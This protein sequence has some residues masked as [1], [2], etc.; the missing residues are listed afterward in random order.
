MSVNLEINQ[1]TR[2]SALSFFYANRAGTVFHHPEVAE[3]L[4]DDIEWWQV[5]KG[6]EPFQLHPVSRGPDGKATVPNFS[7]HFGPYWSDA[8]SERPESSRFSDSQK[9]YK[10]VLDHLSQKYSSFQFELSQS[11]TD[12]RSFLWWNHDNLKPK[13]LITP[14]YS[15]VIRD[16]QEKPLGVLEQNFRELRRREVK[17]AER[18][19]KFSSSSSFN[20]RDV[21]FIY[22][23][24]LARSG[25]E[26]NPP[27]I[28]ESLRKL[29]LLAGSTLARSQATID[30]ETG[31]LASFVFI[32]RAKGVTNLV[33]SLTH[34]DYRNSG[35]G[36]LAIR[37]AI[38]SA[39]QSGDACFDFNGANSPLRG[40]D[41]HSYGADPAL[42][43][44]LESM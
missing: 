2:E 31:T 35:V 39:K 14:R 43:F 3:S 23:E 5:N 16:L 21:E 42:Y 11:D 19:E 25:S 33:L 1:I 32:L 10:L 41:K 12:V 36:A 40:D 37:Q 24:T 13:L 6:S 22:E 44:R 26:V 29:R 28:R 9:I 7:Y 30:I 4:G 17:K 27:Q 34:S 15:A 20:W 18:S 8:F 38:F